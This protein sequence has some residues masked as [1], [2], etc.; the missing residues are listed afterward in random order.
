MP[1]GA[2]Y[3][4]DDYELASRLSFVLWSSIPDDELTAL[5]GQGKLHEP[6]VLQAQVRR[7]LADH[8]AQSLVTNFAAQ[9]L[10]LRNLRSSLPDKEEFPDFDDNLRQSFERETE[11]LFDSVMREDRSVVDLLTADYTFLNE[12]LA[13]H[14]GISG[15]YGSHFRRVTLTDQA[16][17]GLLGQGSILTIT[18]HGNRTSPVV[19]GKWVLD[20]LLGSPPPPPPANVPPLDEGEGAA[21]K[22]M[23]ERMEQHRRSPACANCH[24]I[25][26]PIGLALENFDAIGAWRTADGATPIDASGQLSDGTRVDGPVS[27]RNALLDRRQV[28][29]STMTEKLLTYALGRRVEFYD[30]P[31]VRDIVRQSAKNDYRWSSIVMGVITSRPFQMRTAPAA[32]VATARK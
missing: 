15:V 14:Y 16:R 17:R 9:W 19:R 12:R 10:Q 7:M 25:M 30:M 4:I 6:A 24:K 1:A 27:L 28:F 3:R 2:T 23:R 8:R 32:V 29:V 21:P 13:K 26:D 11:L 22:A 18:S 5:A 20:N 31:T